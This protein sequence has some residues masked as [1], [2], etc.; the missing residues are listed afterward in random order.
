MNILFQLMNK[1]KKVLSLGEFNKYVN[2]QTGPGSGPRSRSGAGP[3]TGGGFTDRF[4]SRQRPGQ[5]QSYD[6]SRQSNYDRQSRDRQ[7]NDRD[8]QSYDRD[9]QSERKPA[10]ARGVQPIVKPNVL[11]TD[12]QFPSF[13][14]KSPVTHTSNIGCWSSGIDTI[15]LAVDLPE[16]KFVRAK[17]PINANQDDYDTDEHSSDEYYSDSSQTRPQTQTQTQTQPRHR[18]RS[19][20]PRSNYQ[21]QPQADDSDNEWAGGF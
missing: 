19:L 7:S 15:K 20:S 13:P 10:H 21:D 2:E 14:S 4:N 11:L 1:T 12:E 3:S 6:R 16:Q 5:G 8:R 18:S 9:R 17:K